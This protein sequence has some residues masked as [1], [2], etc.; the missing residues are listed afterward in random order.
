[1]DIMVATGGGGAGVGRNIFYTWTK[2][3]YN[4][5]LPMTNIPAPPSQIYLVAPLVAYPSLILFTWSTGA[6]DPRLDHVHILL[7]LYAIHLSIY[8]SNYLFIYL[9]Y[10]IVCCLP[11][12][13]V[14]ETLGSSRNNRIKIHSL[15][16][17]KITIESI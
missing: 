9:S 12:E 5:I 7:T 1:M 11:G 2:A 4:L 3:M 15:K 13:L 17:L 10:L 16:N 6:L 8:L 14:P